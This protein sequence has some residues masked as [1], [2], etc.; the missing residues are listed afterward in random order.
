MAQKAVAR[1]DY[2]DGPGDRESERK[3]L[4]EIRIEPMHT[5]GEGKGVLTHTE[6]HHRRG[7]QGGGPLHDVSVEKDFHPTLESLHAHFKE[8]LKDHFEPTNEAETDGEEHRPG[9]EAED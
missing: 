8:H 1:D 7:G 3:E 2:E 4:H 6:Y 5:S 9:T